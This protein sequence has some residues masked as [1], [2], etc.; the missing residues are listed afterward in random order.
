LNALTLSLPSSIRIRSAVMAGLPV[1]NDVPVL[2][3]CLWGGGKRSHT[4]PPL[5]NTRLHMMGE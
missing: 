1:D 5:M 4:M 3:I 2:G